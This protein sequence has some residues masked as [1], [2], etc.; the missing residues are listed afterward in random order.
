M[1]NKVVLNDDFIRRIPRPAPGKRIEI[2]DSLVS[3]F[4]IRVAMGEK[5]KIVKRSF[6][7]RARFPNS[8]HPDKRKAETGDRKNPSRRLIAEFGKLKGIAA[9]VG[10]PPS[11]TAEAREIARSWWSLIGHGVDP[12][13]EQQR[14]RYEARLQRDATFQKVYE[15]WLKEHA[16]TK[17]RA[18]RMERDVRH[19]LLPVLKDRPITAI[20]RG[21]IRELIQVLKE[22][23]G[24]WEARA[25]L[26]HTKSIM[27]FA[28]Q[29]ES[30]GLEVSPADRIPT[31][32]LG[33]FPPRQRV[34]SNDE[35]V[36]VW[37]AANA[38][39]D[40]LWSSFFKLALLLGQRRGETAGMRKSEL[41]FSARVWRLP[42]ERQKMDRS[43]VLPLPNEAFSIIQQRAA[44]VTGDLLFSHS[45]RNPVGHFSRAFALL[46]AEAAKLLE[47]PVEE[48]S[49][50]I[51]DF[52]RTLRTRLS[53]LNVPSEVSER[54][55]G[56]FR[57][58]GVIATY[59]LYERL[60][61]MRQ[62]L[63]KYERFLLNLV[64]P[65]PVKKV[66]QMR[67]RG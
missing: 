54:V 4:S 8:I 67:K 1:A 64:N 57:R 16:S 44:Q 36:A 12:K 21:E 49:F 14:Q 7:L 28:I 56:H 41:D 19:L 26:S 45:G 32:S 46:K 25:A 18:K 40:P 20:T 13:E 6:L 60:P 35:I 39:T 29:T 66:V 17:R 9:K 47:K 52:R 10:A 31:A 62:A 59:D 11:Q 27:H 50:T 43:F 22:K 34:L 38:M 23:H 63:E 48:L 61:E 15:R 5:T 51:H 2:F 37:R 33:T 30:Y 55:I 42:A 53:E 65:A 58:S 3:G 24:K